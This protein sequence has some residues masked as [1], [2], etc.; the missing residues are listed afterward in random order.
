ML[1]GL[2]I[3]VGIAV[4]LATGSWGLAQKER[5]AADAVDPAERGPSVSN[6]LVLKP[7]RFGAEYDQPT[8]G[9]V[10]SCRVVLEGSAWI[11]LN[12]DGVLLRRFEDT[13]RDGKVDSWAYYKAGAEV[14]RDVDSN[15]DGNVDG[16]VE[17]CPAKWRQ[18]LM[19]TSL[20]GYKPGECLVRSD[21]TTGTTGLD[22][23]VRNSVAVKVETLGKPFTEKKKYDS[24]GKRCRETLKVTLT[25]TAVPNE[26]NAEF[27]H[28][29]AEDGKVILRFAGKTLLHNSKE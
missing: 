2:V 25:D 12:G 11:L 4:T 5:P 18:E 26:V 7:R 23:V 14:V 15:N 28:T 9:Q 27:E 22:A 24:Q 6:M 10:D 17:Y 20:I 16:N 29:V 13:N 3:G 19:S 8:G 1:R 21:I